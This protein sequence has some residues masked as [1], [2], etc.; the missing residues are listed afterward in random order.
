[1]RDLIEALVILLKY[2][3]DD[4][5]PT[6]CEHDKLYIFAGIDDKE[7]ISKEDLKRLDELGFF[8]SEVDDEGLIL[9]IDIIKLHM[10]YNYLNINNL[11]LTK[12]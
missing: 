4:R 8:W 5:N 2:A 11:I 3:N 10:I 1:M 7:K 6:H 12:K 9:T